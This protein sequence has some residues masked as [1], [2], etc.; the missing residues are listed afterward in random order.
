MLRRFFY[1]TAPI[2]ALTTLIAVL[3]RSQPLPAPA[4]Q[5]IPPRLS[6]SSANAIMPI[7]YIQLN[8]QLRDLRSLCGRKATNLVPSRGVPR[9]V[10]QPSPTVDDDD[11]TST[12]TP[13]PQSTPTS[14]PSPTK[15]VPQPGA[16]PAPS[17][18]GRPA[19]VQLSPGNASTIAP[20]APNP[21]A[22]PEDRD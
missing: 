5:T 19:S 4:N 6:E 17:P 18:I 11:S 15:P 12:A 20:S 13:K 10:S 21:L 8:G 1:L 9:S 16:S 7:C 3:V 22:I 2:A 14:T